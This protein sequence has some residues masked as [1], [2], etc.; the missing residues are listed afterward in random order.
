MQGE[1]KGASVRV[2]VISNE[3]FVPSPERGVGVMGGSYYTTRDGLELVSIHS[4]TSRSDTTEM[5]YVRRSPDNGQT[6][7]EPQAWPMRF[8]AEEGTGRRHVRGGYVDPLTG[9]YIQVWTEGV[10]PTDEPLE[11]MRRWKL[12]YAVSE[13]GGHTHIVNEQIVCTGDE[14]DA[15]I[16]VKTA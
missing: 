2:K 5:A 1:Y 6:W 10:L 11:G 15:C 13:D 12:H 7:D 4:L 14:Y 16:S 9:R 3:V 8:E